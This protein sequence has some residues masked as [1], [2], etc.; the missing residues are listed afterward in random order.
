VIQQTEAQMVVIGEEGG[1]L[2]PEDDVDN[3][4]IWYDPNATSSQQHNTMTQAAKSKQRKQSQSSSNDDDFAGGG[5]DGGF[6][7]G[8]FDDD[9][10]GDFGSGLVSSSAASGLGELLASTTNFKLQGLRLDQIATMSKIAKPGSEGNNNSNMP[11]TELEEGVEV[12]GFA[13]SERRPSFSTFSFSTTQRHLN[14]STRGQQLYFNTVTKKIQGELPTC[15]ELFQQSILDD[16]PDNWESI[17][18]G[19]MSPYPLY[20]L[21]NKKSLLMWHEPIVVRAF[22]MN[23][24]SDIESNDLLSTV[25]DW[26]VRVVAESHTAYY[27]NRKTHWYQNEIPEALDTYQHSKN[28]IREWDSAMSNTC[29]GVV[30]YYHV[31]PNGDTGCSLLQKPDCIKN[32]LQLPDPSIT[33]KSPPVSA[34]DVRFNAP[35]TTYQDNVCNWILQYNAASNTTFYRNIETLSLS[36]NIPKPLYLLGTNHY[37]SYQDWNQSAI[38]FDVDGNEITPQEKAE[39]DDQAA[40]NPSLVKGGKRLYTEK[41]CYVYTIP[42]TTST[43]KVFHRPHVVRDR[44]RQTESTFDW[45]LTRSSDET[46]FLYKHKTTKDLVSELPESIKT[47][48]ENDVEAKK[49][50]HWVGCVDTTLQ[51]GYYKHKPTNLMLAGQHEPPVLAEIRNR[52]TTPEQERAQWKIFANRVDTRCYYQNNVTKQCI[53]G[54]IPKVLLEWS[55]TTRSDEWN[56]VPPSGTFFRG[57]WLHFKTGTRMWERPE[58]IDSVEV[59]FP[60]PQSPVAKP[61]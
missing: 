4:I 22:R 50:E 59:A 35:G 18:S 31:L 28:N 20:R 43:I 19:T 61:E 16:T 9:D 47:W 36:L 46:H 26:S 3:W 15:F 25:P 55:S 38:Y 8:D 13:P 41:V 44:L 1:S 57:Y 30:V 6:G 5:L 53:I 45:S 12:G 10:D 11:R 17:V 39:L 21:V 37:S 49:A 42:Q 29:A 33:T 23:Q 27:K 56:F 7:G 2:D 60:K 52:P 58:F 24:Y 51:Q 48:L 32:L 14:L 40:K 34:L 54:S